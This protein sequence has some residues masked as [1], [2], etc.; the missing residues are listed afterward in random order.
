MRRTAI[1]LAVF[2]ATTLLAQS[3]AYDPPM[4]GFTSADAAKERTLEGQFDSSL[5]RD[6][7]R[8]WM[9]RLSARPHHLG[10]AYDHDNALFIASLFKS[11]GYDTNIEEFSVLFPTPKKRLVEL[12][13]PEHFTAKLVEPPVPGDATSGQQS[14]QLP[15]Y[16]AY[17]IDGDVTGDLVYANYGIP[18]DYEILERNGIDVKGKIVI[19]R[20]GGSW[21]GIKP[22]V[23]AEHGAIGCI[24]YSDPKDDGYAQGDVYPK[25]AWRNENGAQ[26]GSVMDMPVHPG[27]PLTP[28]VGATKDA[29]R[30]DRKDA[31]VITKI[32]VLPI[33][34]SDA[35]PLLRAL[36]GPV[37]PSEWRGALPITYHMGPGPS[38]V[39]LALEFNWN[40]VPAYDV[41]ARMT[42]SQYPDEWIMR[43]NHHDAWVN[44]AS[45]PLSGQ[46]AQLEEAKAIAELAKTGWRPKRTIQFAAWDGEE[47]GLIGSTE[48]AETHADELRSKG[49]VYINSDTNSR[50][51]LDSAGSHTLEKLVTQVARD[52]N[53]PE[54][55]VSVLARLRA[56]EA[57]RESARGGNTEMRREA[58]DGDLIRLDA[59]GSG[60][61]YT[62]FLQHTG[63]AA[64]NIGYGGEGGGGSYHSVYDSFDHYT[65]FEDPTFDYGVVQAKTTGRLVLRL[66][67]ADVL[68]FELKTFADT[69]SRYLD[70]LTKLAETTRRE[71]DERNRLVREHAYENAADP[72]KTFVAPKAEPAAPYLNF[73]P[74]QNAVAHLMKSA[75]EFDRAA[76]AAPAERQPAFDRVLMHIEQSL[77][78]PNGLP[79]RPWFRH[80]IYAPGFYTGYGVKTVPGV[81]EAIEQKQ[82][83]DAN[84]Q[85]ESVSKVIEGYVAEVEKATR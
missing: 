49:V 83:S 38:R 77:L 28:G 6:D 36:G 7:L 21:R 32:P 81:R 63:V 45:D 37:A 33:S 55:N 10:S 75:Q 13:A 22:K 71:I 16:N 68:P 35:L 20:Y 82:W 5:N 65:R 23:A 29:K 8:D 9:K 51:F 27:D 80:Q 50:G 11:W 57:T 42:G 40:M 69:L 58:H 52:V 18:A 73:A 4:L 74:L 3:P 54:R 60:S 59:L 53:D 48:W 39:H 56:H 79:R 15:V 61:D 24:I 70:E 85:I 76:A 66:A 41:I 1:V 30:I 72:T 64:L 2:L 78:L 14:E 31:E 46:V 26:R 43:G 34:Y 47:E 62:P 17:S 67:N 19:T 25:G 12:I 44:G 84:A